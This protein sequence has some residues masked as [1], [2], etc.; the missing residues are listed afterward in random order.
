MISGLKKIN[1]NQIIAQIFGLI[2]LGGG[3]SMF[4]FFLGGGFLE[5]LFYFSLH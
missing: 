5:K 3:D 1:M 2:F 4:L